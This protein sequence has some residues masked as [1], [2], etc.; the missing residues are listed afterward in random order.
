MLGTRGADARGAAR[1]R[2]GT[3]LSD[4]P[5]GLRLPSL[6]W[7]FSAGEPLSEGLVRRWRE[8]FPGAGGIVNLYG[9]TETTLAKCFHRVADPPAPGIQPVGSPLPHTQALVLGRSGRLCG[10][11]ELGEIVL[12]TPFRSLGYVN[13]AI[14]SARRFRPNPFAAEAGELLYFTGDGGRY[15]LDGQLAIYGRLDDQVK[16]RGMRV[17]PAEIRAVLESH[18]QVSSSVVLARKDHAG[19]PQLVAWVVADDGFRLAELRE[20]LR[21]KLPDYMVP[22]A[23]V[24]LERLPLLPN[25]KVDRRALPAPE[26]VGRETESG[27]RAPRDAV[28][29]ALAQLWE[30][31]LG[32]ERIDVRDDFFDLGGHS[33]L[34]VRL[35]A[36]I[37]TRFGRELPLEALFR[38]ATV[39]RLA[40]VLRE[41]GEAVQPFLVEIQGG[42]SRLPLFCIHPV[43]GTVLCYG[44]L[45][46]ALGPEQPV[47]AH[48]ARGL[49][50]GETP[51]QRIEEMAVSYLRAVREVRPQGPYVLLG[52]SM[53]GVVAYEMARQLVDA[54]QEV[55]LLALVDTR[56]RE[57]EEPRFG[58][59]ADMFAWAISDE[60]SISLESI[61][62]LDAEEQLAAVLR[63][64]GEAGV[65]PPDFTVADARRQLDVYQA[66][67]QAAWACRPEPYAGRVVLFQATEEPISVAADWRQVVGGEIEV[68]RVPGAHETMVYPP[69]VRVLAEQLQ[70]LLDGVQ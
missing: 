66:C 1:Q 2:S 70:L 40:A 64:A 15:R 62:S 54:G 63:E 13:A 18:P 6:R 27:T 46:R 26:A 25:G 28:E 22:A 41:D 7:V 9:P 39:E 55:A 23:V 3:W 21:E 31:L 37:R 19:A 35:M 4:V 20:W 10:I 57:V 8:V 48:R 14:E 59:E 36:A 60:M 67:R 24:P 43:M 49:L 51:Q 32:V 65:V 29:L 5:A 52:W 34:A 12:R 30:E 38:G 69:H 61:R 53:G 45:A 58:T 50:A 42:G 11:G 17:E 33:L 68:H 56:A 47:Y 16:I 44:D